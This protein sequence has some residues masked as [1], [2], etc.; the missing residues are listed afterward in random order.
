MNAPKLSVMLAESFREDMARIEKVF[1]DTGD[2]RWVASQ[3]ATRVDALAARLYAELILPDLEGPEGFCLLA[4]G[5]YGRRELFPHSDIDL[6]FL[7]ADHRKEGG[8]REAVATFSRELWDLR[9]RVGHTSRTLSE[10]GVFQNGNLE[11]HIACLDCRYLAGDR[12]LFKSL[13]D[14]VLPRFV[15][16]ERR[17][18]VNELIQVTL[19]R[20]AK[21]GDTVFHLEPNLKEAP[22]GLRDY[23]VACWLG[24]IRQ[25]EQ[26]GQ[27]G[28]ATETWPAAL[29]QEAR[30][31]VDFLCAVRCFLHYKVKRDEN[32][33]TY[34]LQEGAAQHGIGIANRKILAPAD[35]IRIFFRHART[36]DRLAAQA[37]DDNAAP[38]STLYGLFK[39][40][41]S[42]LENPDFAVVRG[43]IYPRQP[44]AILQDP[45]VLLT[46]FEFMARHGLE[47]SRET[48]KWVEQH[49]RPAGG[50]VSS[51]PDLGRRIAQILVL[52]HAARALR[53]MHRLGL[54]V[55][56]FPEW[57]AI[58]ALVVRDFFHRYTVDEHTL[59]TIQHLHELDAARQDGEEGEDAGGLRKWKKCFGDILSELEQPEALYL[60][61]L[62]HDVGKGMPHPSHVQG[63]LQALDRVLP[64]LA[65]GKD[66]EENI[67]FLISNH[68]AMSATVQRRDIFDPET[69]KTFAAEVRNPE[70]LKMLTL[71]TF[72]DI[73]SVNPEAMT[74]WKAEMLWRLYT[75]TSNYFTHSLDADRV[76]TAGVDQALAAQV[77]AVVPQAAPTVAAQFL[78]GFPHR[79]VATHSPEEIAGHFR[80]A[81]GLGRNPA[82]IALRPHQRLYELT[83]MTQDRPRLFASITGVL[84]SWGFNIVKADAFANSNGCILDVF[85][86]ADLFRTLELNPGEVERFK[87]SLLD[88][89]SGRQKLETLLR[90]RL[91][92][93]KL[94]QP[95][96]KVA[97]LLHF[98]DQS[99]TRCTL[100]ELITADRPGLLHKVST[101][102]ADQCC[103]IEVALIDTEGKKAI[104][105]FYLTSK[106]AK[107]TESS[108]QTVRHA[109]MAVLQ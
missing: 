49:L 89:L 51:L 2:G 109:L 11:F 27:W 7:S 20:H 98:D 13:H 70:C 50:K 65:L 19:Q 17:D 45:T 106:G 44:A 77:A 21:H 75:A 95:K 108:Q 86:F 53:A 28:D 72:T 34:E 83:V 30:Q 85:H 81:L 59:M 64:R 107:L 104:D 78:E 31:A 88:V 43:R 48:E 102:L 26:T 79:Y 80:M 82:E 97:T 62:F 63:S 18:L 8:F 23:Q 24:T 92:D 42:R 36:I 54:L 99:S 10:C 96:V 39:D 12:N 61:L 1:A 4:L 76:S 55:V 6:L 5:G 71:F 94:P 56:L 57:R 58:D 9:L 93:G 87:K 66:A 68:L 103:N 91:Q 47:P 32:L 90:G 41:M 84:A 74:P 100:M 69:V 105:V 15:A 38:E 3:R 60:A 46:L 73:H 52:P 67:R 35:W 40:W 33:L 22:G 101:A 29:K 14:E 25:L 16:R 37:L